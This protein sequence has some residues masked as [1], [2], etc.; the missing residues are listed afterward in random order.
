MKKEVRQLPLG[1]G[2][3]VSTRFDEY[4]AGTSNA[5]A[6]HALRD[7]V[8]RG[9]LVHLRGPAATGKTHLLHA[10][11]NEASRR[12]LR[13]AYLP[14]GREQAWDPQVLEAWDAL[15]RVHLDD[16]DKVIGNRAWEQVL[17]RLYDNLRTRHAG[18]LF[19][20]TTPLAELDFTLPDLAS[21]LASAAAFRLQ[22]LDDEALLEAFRRRLHRR[23]IELPEE[24]GSW[25]FKRVARDMHSLSAL[26]ERLDR[27]SLSAQRRLTIPFLREVLD[28]APPAG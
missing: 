21:R 3:D 13:A 25:L 14:L 9:G 11:C 20:T 17:M 24:A 22:P 5:A 1:L 4:V 10:S 12:G 28:Q 7:A 15:D 2:L 18:L 6:V 23:G 16:I 26:A 8:E 27:L 19:S